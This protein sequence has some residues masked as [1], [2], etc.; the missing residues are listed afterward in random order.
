MSDNTM[1]KEGGC[2]CGAVRYRMN[3]KPMYVHCCHCTDCQRHSGSA[4]AL[5]ALIE[6]GRLDLLQGEVEA[7]VVPTPSGKG[8]TIKR[9]PTCKT[10][11][12]SH[13]GAAGPVLSLVRV[14]TVDQPHGIEPDMHIFTRSKQPWVNLPDDVPT[15]EVF[16]DAE[17]L[18]PEE[19]LARRNALFAR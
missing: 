13:Y 6:S 14:G 3:D 7:I 11:L 15:V 2:A 12:W 5:N 18:W 19:S 10:A 8:Q 16:Y 9:C 4:F 1:V 17:E